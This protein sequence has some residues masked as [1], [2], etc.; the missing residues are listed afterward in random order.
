MGKVVKKE[1]RI[2][3]TRGPKIEVTKQKVEKEESSEDVA[4]R[5]YLGTLL[6]E[7]EEI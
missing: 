4:R 3:M 6:E 7:T 5:K 1:G 2:M